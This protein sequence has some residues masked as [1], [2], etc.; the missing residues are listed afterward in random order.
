W[1]KSAMARAAHV[2]APAV[3]RP[4]SIRVSFAFHL[5]FLRVSFVSRNARSRAFL[6]CARAVREYSAQALNDLFGYSSGVWGRFAE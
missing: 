6:R 2:D 4:I 5:L 1:L 3:F